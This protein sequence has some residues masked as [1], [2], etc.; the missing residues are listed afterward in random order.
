MRFPRGCS[1]RSDECCSPCFP[2]G[3]CAARWRAGLPDGVRAPEAAP[4]ERTLANCHG[5]QRRAPLTTPPSMLFD[6]ARV[7]PGLLPGSHRSAAPRRAY[8][9]DRSFLLE[10]AA[11]THYL[12][13]CRLLDANSRRRAAERAQSA[14][15][16]I[17]RSF[18]GAAPAGPRQRA[19][20]DKFRLSSTA[21]RETPSPR[22]RR[23]IA[24]ERIDHYKAPRQPAEAWAAP[25]A[26]GCSS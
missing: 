16:A 12:F 22:A 19:A 18:R 3:D 17:D 10:A 20:S 9:R 2:R 5:D 1:A 15:K 8:V 14:N 6:V 23:R 11:R 25:F 21:R 26:G 7:A 13:L 24:D 4:A